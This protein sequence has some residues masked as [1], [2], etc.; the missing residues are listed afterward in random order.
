M[1]K[2]RNLSDSQLLEIVADIL[3]Q[4]RDLTMTDRKEL[5]AINDELIIR[6]AARAAEQKEK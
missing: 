1:T 5:F 4:P 3:A 2:I 6:D